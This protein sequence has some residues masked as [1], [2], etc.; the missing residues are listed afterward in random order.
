M[1]SSTGEK[2]TYLGVAVAFLGLAVALGIT[3]DNWLT[4]LPFAVIA[5]T[6]VALGTERSKRAGGTGSRSDDDA[7]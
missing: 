5:L 1:S 2:Q 7:D 3:L 6:F 4:A